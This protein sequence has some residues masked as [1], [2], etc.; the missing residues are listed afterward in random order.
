[1]FDI[2]IVIFILRWSTEYS[3]CIFVLKFTYLKNNYFHFF[4]TISYT[5][6]ENFKKSSASFNFVYWFIIINPIV[7]KC[8]PS[9]TTSTTILS[10]CPIYKNILSR[11]VSYNS[12]TLS[13][14]IAV[15]FTTDLYYNVTANI[16]NTFRPVVH[17]PRCFYLS[18]CQG[19]LTLY[20][21][22]RSTSQGASV[23]LSDWKI[24]T[25]WRKDKDV[26]FR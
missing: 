19:F 1:M 24:L 5:L 21:S 7:Y 16:V 18:F 22:D 10:L 9:A 23:M 13:Y 2:C 17:W 12:V 25:I 6:Y 15:S 3:W 14:Q 20:K 11:R 26:N 4:A 8:M